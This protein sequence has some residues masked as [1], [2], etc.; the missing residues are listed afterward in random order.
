MSQE[1][2]HQKIFRIKK[3][4][5]ALA[6]HETECRLCPREC[7][8]DR[9][10]GESGYCGGSLQ[11]I[12][13]SHALLHFGEEPVLSGHEDCAHGSAGIS[14]NQKGSGTIFFSGCNLKCAGCQNYQISHEYR[15]DWLSPEA[16]G[17]KMLDLQ[18]QGALNINLVSP[19]HVLPAVLR[20]LLY[21]YEHGLSL[22]LVYNTHGFEK[23][24]VIR[25]LDG[26]VDIYLPDFK[27][28]SRKLAGRLSQ[29]PDYFIRASKSIHEMYCQQPVLA[30]NNQGTA[31]KG[32]IIRHLVLPGQS[33]DSI[34][35][36]E[37]IRRHISASIGIS[38]MSQ[39]R[40][41]FHA[42]P[43]MLRILTP[44]EYQ[45]AADKAADLGFDYLFLQ[46]GFLE[47]EGL[48][49]DFEL[50]TPFKWKPKP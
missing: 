33:D 30:L 10:A 34:R 25:L 1:Q 39:Y 15:G 12:K 38:L 6:G 13:I 46:S 28:Y 19:A 26:I 16:L 36:L 35:I 24:D 45:R 29:A 44:D 42:P 41:C 47:P 18:K 5:E 9:L 50:D 3:A 2:Q 31:L 32:C 20:G 49:P 7:C 11:K 40:P 14:V 27:Y 48:L 21:A 8:A 22:P 37:W 4:L 43:D 17:Q 23:A